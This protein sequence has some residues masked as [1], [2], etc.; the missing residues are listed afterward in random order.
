M[1]KVLQG[2]TNF[3]FLKFIKVLHILTM[4]IIALLNC[5]DN[6]IGLSFVKFKLIDVFI[7]VLWYSAKC[8]NN[9]WYK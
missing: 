8:S 9:N 6:I 7:Q 5:F 3:Y 1:F 4:P 2:F